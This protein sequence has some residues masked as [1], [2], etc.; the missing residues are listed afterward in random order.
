MVNGTNGPVYTIILESTGK[1]YIGGDFIG[2]DYDGAIPI[3]T[4]IYRLAKWDGTWKF[5]GTNASQNGTDKAVHALYYD[6]VNFLLYVGGDF[7][8]VDYN[9]TIGGTS[10][11]YIAYCNTTIPNVWSSL[12]SNGT[13]GSVNAIASDGGKIYV[14]GNF[15]LVN[16]TG[17]GGTSAYN[18]AYWDGSLWNQLTVGGIGNGVNGQV[19]SI[20]YDSGTSEYYIGGSFTGADYN[21]SIT[22]LG[23]FYNAV[24]WNGVWN[25]IGD[26]SSINNG[27]N[28]TV[29]SIYRNFNTNTFMGG[30][31]NLIG[32]DG[33]AGVK[34]ANNIGYFDGNAKWF[35]L[36]Y[37]SHSPGVNKSVYAL[38][39]IGTDL[40]VGGNFTS[41][42]FPPTYGSFLQLNYIARWN[43]V[44][45]VWYPLIYN[46]SGTSEIGLNGPV[47]AL[48]TNGTL[49]YVGGDFTT[50]NGGFA[51]NYIGVWDP[52]INTWT[53]IIT[54]IGTNIGLDDKVYGLS[55]RSPYTNLYVG[56]AFI[57]TNNSS[58]QLNYISRVDLTNFSTGFQQI[59]D[60]SLNYGTNGTVNTVLDS[61]PYIYF[62][63]VFSSGGSGVLMNYLG[64]YLYIYI[65]NAVVLNAGTGYKFLDTQT[66]TITSTFT[67]TNKFKSV[68]LINSEI[69]SP[70]NYWLIMYRS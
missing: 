59:L 38:T 43:T 5:I 41:L 65:S 39:V 2:T 67:L 60:S 51:L 12:G 10:A 33:L 14:G 30:N 26:T 69:L 64:Y 8:L 25:I 6:S 53:Q 63:G 62:G 32:Y 13:N 50:T 37:S 4:N 7:K 18:I 21:G 57:Y 29:Y 42:N 47:N 68:I 9:G 52:L 54:P 16:Y 40:Y 44:N 28:G 20:Y 35:N 58:K 49:L 45:E 27:T 15:S 55:C 24:M 70:I 46:N 31:F 19:R 11:N 61:Y 56:G 23:P 48:A 3:I 17:T 1:Y 36:E 22:S 66:G 34:N